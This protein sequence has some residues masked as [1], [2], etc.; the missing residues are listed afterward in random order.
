M[1]R[2]LVI[3][4]KGLVLFNGKLLIVKRSETNKFGAGTWEMIG[5]KLQVGEELEDALMREAEEEVGISVIPKRLLY[6]TTINSDPTRQLVFLNYLSTSNKDIVNL[7]EEH[8]DY[9]WA[10]KSEARNLLTPKMMHDF[11]KHHV[12]D[13]KEWK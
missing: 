6:A 1:E 5:G 3:V 8:T 10:T 9:I 7:S 2:K 13:L 4:V 11:E 12:F